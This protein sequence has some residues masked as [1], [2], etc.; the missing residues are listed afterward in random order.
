MAVEQVIIDFVADY[1][2]LQPAIDML[3]KAGQ[4]DAS[5]AQNF[6][7]TNAEINKQAQALRSVSQ[8]TS[9]EAQSID[10][11]DKRMKSFLKNA[12][13]GFEEGVADALKEAGV[14]M[15]EFTTALKDAGVA[16]EKSTT[17]LRQELKNLTQQI[18]QAKVNG[19]D[20]GEEYQTLV[21]RAGELRDAIADAGA[22]ISNAGSDTRHL[23][24]VIGTVQALAGGYALVQGATG[25]P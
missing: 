15:D 7:Q 13:Q 12:I 19:T 4:I 18:A 21:A 22:E 11:M 20:L 9:Q 14:S 5:I 3:E 6:K 16:G 2:G 8:A 17:S 23:D 10:Q 1:S 24:N 25:F